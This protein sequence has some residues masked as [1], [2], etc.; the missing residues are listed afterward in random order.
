MSHFANRLTRVLLS[1]LVAIF[2]LGG[3]FAAALEEGDKAP[4]FSLQASDGETY[5]LS[6][7]AGDKPVVIAFF[8]KAFTGGWTMQCKALRDSAREIQSF[9]V[10]YFMA[11]VDTLEDNTAFAAEH[12]ANF[13]I[14]ADPEKEMTGEY[15][16]LMEVG[17]ANRW[18]FYIDTDGT[19]LK[20]DKETNPAT[21]GRDLVANMNELGFNK[22]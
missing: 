10:A 1:A 13:P 8:P 20:I 18:T 6:Q 22:I 21:A 11:S 5:T 15:D 4:D 2:A 3:Q 9:D 12:E 16:V 19:I 14:L 17:F 7:F